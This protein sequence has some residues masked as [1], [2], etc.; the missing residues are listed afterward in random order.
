L[1]PDAQQARLAEIRNWAR[2][3]PN[4]RFEYGALSQSEVQTLG[5][6]NLIEIGAHTVNHANLSVLAAKQ[7]HYE[8]TQSKTTL[9]T[10]LDRPVKS[11]AYTFGRKVDYNPTTTKLVQ[12]S[13]FNCACS[14]FSGI[15][16][17]RRNDFE[18][19]RM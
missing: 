2:F 6:G 3:K 10:I 19:P 7:Q 4:I 12:D 16:G 8:I 9:E 17:P 5:K 18:L 1:P 15:I 13:G 14:N 11:F